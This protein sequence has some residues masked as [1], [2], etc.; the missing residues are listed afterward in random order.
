MELAAKWDG[1][2]S[3]AYTLGLQ[4]H[5]YHNTSKLL[6]NLSLLDCE[7]IELLGFDPRQGYSFEEVWV[8]NVSDARLRS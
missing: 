6:V 1:L 8:N 2:C 3:R 5:A 4:R 7:I